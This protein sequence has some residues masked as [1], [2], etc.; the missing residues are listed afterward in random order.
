MNALCFSL[1]GL[2]LITTP[3]YLFPSGGPQ[4]AHIPLLLIFLLLLF[5]YG[6]GILKTPPVRVFVWMVFYATCANLCFWFFSDFMEYG[7]LFSSL[8]FLFN[9]MTL[10]VTYAMA[11]REGGFLVVYYALTFIALVQVCAFFVL[12]MNYGGA[13]YLAF[14]NDPN[15]LS[16]WALFATVVFAAQKQ[17]GKISTAKFLVGGGACAALVLLS[18]SRGGAL[19]LACMWIIVFWKSPLW[20]KLLLGA[21]LAV[22]LTVLLPYIEEMSFFSRVQ[23]LSETD[24]G[25][26]RHWNRLWEFPFYNILGAGE[27]D[28][29][30]FDVTGL[31]VHSTIFTV[32]F[33]YGLPGLFLYFAFIK[34][35]VFKNLGNNLIL[36]F[37]PLVPSFISVN[38]IRMTSLYVM[39]GCLSALMNSRNSGE[40]GFRRDNTPPPIC[41]AIDR[42]LH[43]EKPN[44][45]NVSI[46]H[47]RPSEEREAA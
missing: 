39:F 23:T 3:L 7:F 18:V 30:R 29:Y 44:E 32:L 34:V 31:E 15:Q 47:S 25:A 45:D 4:L 22:S 2:F 19:A 33:C 46:F 41:G 24:I 14:F 42:E 35:C 26:D 36:L 40:A 43:F 28:Y 13:R 21:I 6:V 38:M 1:W 5:R 12:G 16:S 11:N 37:L 10:S 27:G 8:Y 20:A 17:Y 9:V